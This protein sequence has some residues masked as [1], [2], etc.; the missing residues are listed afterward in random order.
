MASTFSSSCFSN[1]ETCVIWPT[2]S[3]MLMRASRSSTRS[4]RVSGRYAGAGGAKSALIRRISTAIL[5][6]STS[7]ERQR[8]SGHGIAALR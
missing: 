5:H 8:R 2:F 7:P 6:G 3:S 4:T 1:K